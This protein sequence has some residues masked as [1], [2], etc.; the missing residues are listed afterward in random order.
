MPERHTTLPHYEST[1]Y[2]GSETFLTD[3][4]FSQQEVE[5]Y[6]A[7]V[8]D[9]YDSIIPIRI[10]PVTFISG[11]DYR[12]SGWEISAINYPKIDTKP[13]TIDKF[14]SHLAELLVAKFSQH[15]ICVTNGELITMFVKDWDEGLK[16]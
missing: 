3:E 10:T 15:R 13:E 9:D 11:S 12:E 5:D 2:M 1:L 16:Y 7:S 6:I 4:K 14:M 8:Q